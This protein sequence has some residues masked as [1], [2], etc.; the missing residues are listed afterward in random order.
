LVQVTEVG[1]DSLTADLVRQIE[2]LKA[3]DHLCLVYDHDPAEQMPA[4]LPY[5]AQGLRRGERCVY[6]ADDQAV[7]DVARALEG[8]GIDVEKEMQREALLLWT[9]RDW[10]L[11]GELTSD[12]KTAQVR[13]I[14]DRALREG[15]AAV[16][17]AIEMTWTLGSD[18]DPG[19]LRHW[20]ATLDGIANEKPPA[21]IVCQYSRS[22]LPPATLR[23]A[24]STHPMVILGT[25]LCPN[26]Y[27]AG[28]L[29]L[30]GNSEAAAVDW[31]FMQLKTAQAGRRERE[32]RIRAEAALNEAE[33]AKAKIS[34]LYQLA[35]ETAEDLA[36]ASQA[37]DEFLALISH[38][39]R[40][41][42]TTILGNAAILQSRGQALD[43]ET[44]EQAIED[45]HGEA[46][47]LHSIINDL[48]VL[49]RIDHGYKVA[50]EP[51]LVGRLV[52]RVVDDFRRR[53]SRQEID[54]EIESPSAIAAGE[55][56]YVEDVLRNFLSN[57]AKYSPANSRVAVRVAAHED[58]V[59]VSVLD[60]GIGLTPEELPQLFSPFYRSP[61]VSGT[62]RGLGIGLAVCRRLIEVQDG[63]IWA[64][65][66]PDGGS[67]F[68]FAL[69]VAASDMAMSHG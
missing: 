66:R 53:S 11:A 44:R 31:M 26:P 35:H 58:E 43:T 7:G 65:P 5:M 34:E 38:E 47:R 18:I 51:V 14:I 33:R 40:T 19:R 45:V 10:R 30:N 67:E 36:R 15:F 20:E 60:R 62:A 3:G 16:R 52:E 9:R 59:V 1:G 55:S 50:R 54:V 49:A 42:I 68:S 39:L 28:P 61:R 56:G 64:V 22:R 8:D 24:L 6:V 13:A 2:D 46:V 25:D 12:S 27:F 41:P 48:L 32:A 69:P 57:A 63:R 37:K 4:L 17:F 29:I 23:A 21:R